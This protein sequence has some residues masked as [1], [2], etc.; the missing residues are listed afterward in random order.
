MCRQEKL[1]AVGARGPESVSTLGNSKRIYLVPRYQ[2]EPPL[3][4]RRLSSLR[5]RYALLRST[6]SAVPTIGGSSLKPFVTCK[7]RAD[8]LLVQVSDE[9][10]VGCRGLRTPRMTQVVEGLKGTAWSKPGKADPKHRMWIEH[11]RQPS[12]YTP[13]WAIRLR[14]CRASSGWPRIC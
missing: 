10:T 11:W 8:L 1:T 4:T 3:R 14:K 2:S 12:R 6:S 5:V 7:P 13:V 9:G